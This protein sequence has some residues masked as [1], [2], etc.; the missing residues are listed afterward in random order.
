MFCFE[1]IIVYIELQRSQN[2]N[3][4][5]ARQRNERRPKPQEKLF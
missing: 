5:I 1:V 4:R 2:R 3:F